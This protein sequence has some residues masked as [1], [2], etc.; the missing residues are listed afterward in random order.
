[1][2][3]KVLWIYGC[4]SFGAGAYHPGYI[5][6]LKKNKVTHTI[7]YFDLHTKNYDLS[8]IDRIIYDD[9]YSACVYEGERSPYFEE[10]KKKYKK[11]KFEL[12]TE[13]II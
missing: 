10:F 9:S 13:R 7:D 4:N 8:D 5:E 11:Y 12:R 6:E 2:D 3:K 1:M